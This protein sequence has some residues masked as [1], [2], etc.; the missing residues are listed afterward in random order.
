MI[1]TELPLSV[2]T[3][4]VVWLLLTPPVC[5]EN[6]TLVDPAAAVTEL[7]TFRETAFVKRMAMFNPPAGAAA[8][9]VILQVA[10]VCAVSSVELHVN[11]VSVTGGG[12]GGA[13]ASVKF[14]EVPFKLAANTAVLFALTVDAVAVKPAELEPAGTTTDDG[15]VT[16]DP[17]ARPV[18]TVSP[19]V[20]AGAETVTVHA[21]EPGVITVAGEQISPVAV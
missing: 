13:S 11:P 6:W 21:A 16:G 4:V 12:G 5:M 3:R 15:I 8:D 9:S 17:E 20:G 14:M 2:A 10:D 18:A 7:G 19:P 1:L